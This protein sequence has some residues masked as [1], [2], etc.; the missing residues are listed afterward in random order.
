MQGNYTASQRHAQEALALAAG[1]GNP[2]TAAVAKRVAGMT[3]LAMGQLVP[4][5]ELLSEGRAAAEVVGSQNR[6]AVVRHR[7]DRTWVHP[8]SQRRISQKRRSSRRTS[9]Q[10]ESTTQS[11]SVLPGWP[12][13][14]PRGRGPRSDGHA[15]ACGP[16]TRARCRRRLR[17]RPVTLGGRAPSHHRRIPTRTRRHRGPA[18]RSTEL[19]RCRIVI[20]LGQAAC[21]YS[22]RVPLSRSRRWISRCRTCAGT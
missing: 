7:L 13:A 1:N 5:E 16:G 4:A 14:W 17:G 8:A 9:P 3:H 6:D 18:G 20:R 15:S 21:W 12:A 10:T 11:N 22:C 2:Q 19:C